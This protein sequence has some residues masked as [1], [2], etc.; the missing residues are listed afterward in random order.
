MAQLRLLLTYFRTRVVSATDTN[1]MSTSPKWPDDYGPEEKELWEEMKKQIKEDNKEIFKKL[2]KILD[3]MDFYDLINWWYELE[4]LSTWWLYVI[5]NEENKKRMER[6][7]ASCIPKTDGMVHASDQKLRL[8]GFYESSNTT[9]RNFIRKMARMKSQ[10]FVSGVYMGKTL[11][12]ILFNTFYL[13]VIKH[14]RQEV[15]SRFEQHRSEVAT[16]INEPIQTVKV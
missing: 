11:K 13:K 2:K 4:I 10:A 5:Y 7:V 8:N 14:V 9:T 6:K 16:K 1:N 15:V 3:A 12:M